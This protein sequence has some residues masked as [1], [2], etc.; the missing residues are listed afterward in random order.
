MTHQSRLLKVRRLALSPVF[1]MRTVDWWCVWCFH[2]CFR[3]CRLEEKKLWK[4][5]SSVFFACQPASQ[6]ASFCLSSLWE[7]GGGG[8]RERLER[9]T[10]MKHWKMLKPFSSSSAL[11]RYGIYCLCSLGWRNFF[12]L[13]WDLILHNNNN[14][15]FLSSFNT[16]RHCFLSFVI[17]GAEWVSEWVNKCVFSR[18]TAKRDTGLR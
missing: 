8:Q 3:W 5:F 13:I 9:K 1:R 12:S 7:R 4:F 10:N 2:L 17:A 16:I 11:S 14:F 15:L 6:P 18:E